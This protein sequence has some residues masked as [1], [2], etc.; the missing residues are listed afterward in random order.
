[1]KNK[2]TG[3]VVATFAMFAATAFIEYPMPPEPNFGPAP[4]SMTFHDTDP[5]QTIG[6]TL[7]MARAIDAGGN[8]VDEIKEG[9]ITYI[10]HWGLEVGE[11]GTADDEGNGDLGGDCK[12]FRD[13]N[14]ITMVA[15]D[16]LEGSGPLI[17]MEIPQGT[18]V[19]A[20]AVYFVGHTVYAKGNLH[21]L[22]K[23]IQIPIVNVVE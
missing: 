11:P 15:A 17:E 3:I 7:T 21:N 9:I 6:G 18:L 1:M 8:R 10:T 16:S 23:C 12:G 14:H 2:Y 5:G 20:N 4:G 19:P 22:N 13:T